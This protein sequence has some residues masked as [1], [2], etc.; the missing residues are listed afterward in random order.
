MTPML[1][2]ALIF[3]RPTTWNH[4]G[5]SMGYRVAKYLVENAL[6]RLQIIPSEGT[7]HN[8]ACFEGYL[9]HTS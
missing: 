7:N 3:Q 2:P 8:A 1:L 9:F 4:G 6:N 5:P